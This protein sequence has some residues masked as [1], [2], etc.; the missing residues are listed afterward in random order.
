MKKYKKWSE[1]AREAALPT[2]Q[3]IF[4]LPFVKELAEGTLPKEKFLF[5]IAQDSIYI[6]NYSRILAHIASRLPLH[7]QSMDFLKFATEGF[8]VE[9]VLHESYLGNNPVKEKPTPTTLLYNSFESAKCLG[10]VEVETASIL[11]CFWVYKEVGEEILKKCQKDNPYIHWIETYGDETFAKSNLRAIEICDELASNASD[12][13][14]NKMTEAF[15][16]ATKMEW[17]FWESAYNLERW[18]I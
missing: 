4:E 1:E 16:M 14:R 15:V 3:K 2:I 12:D 13:V 9:K 17:M 7:E 5:Y 6:E 11:P 10:P 8:A 18:K